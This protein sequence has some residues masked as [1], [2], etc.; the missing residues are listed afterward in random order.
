MNFFYD[1][2]FVKPAGCHVATPWHQD[3]T[4]WPVE[5][6]QLCSIW[7]TF[8]DVSRESSGLEFVRGSHR[9][10]NR[11]KAVTPDYN[12]Y[13]M[14]SDLED[15]PDI[16]SHR[17]DFDL[18]CWDMQPG[19]VIL[20]NSLVVHGSTGNHTTD[21]PR[22]AFSTR[23]AG[24]DVCFAPRHATMPLF[25]QHDLEPGD[26]LGG[27]LFPRILPEPIASEGA[28]RRRGPEPQ[29]PE[30]TRAAVARI[31]TGM[32]ARRAQPRAATA[33]LDS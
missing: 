26:P 19:D 13:M 3:V 28:R 22:R 18:V 16:D 5:G 14:D 31:K 6:E 7:I 29:D 25:W 20:F 12:P 33:A 10:P 21:Q 17:E 23:W 15:P 4:F 2:L 11:Y 32:Q 24:D 8:D 9:W 1:Q 30:I 27:P